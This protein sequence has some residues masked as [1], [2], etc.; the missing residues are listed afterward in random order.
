MV[1]RRS[2]EARRILGRWFCPHLPCEFVL[3]FL[4]LGLFPCL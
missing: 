1:L 2:G 4:S 3:T